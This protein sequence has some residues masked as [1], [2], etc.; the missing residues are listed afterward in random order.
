MMTK[1][2]SEYLREAARCFPDKIALVDQ[3]REVSYQELLSGAEHIASG[4]IAAG[5][6]RQ[7]VLCCLTGS[8]AIIIRKLE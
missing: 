8:G 4:L 5:L 6:F 3:K 2:V 1:N 7:P